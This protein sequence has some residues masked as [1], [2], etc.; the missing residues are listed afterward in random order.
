MINHDSVLSGKVE[1]IFDKIADEASVEGITDGEKIYHK[2]ESEH[3]IIIIPKRM[4]QSS[5]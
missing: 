2:K 4:Q 5:R 3:W 1:E